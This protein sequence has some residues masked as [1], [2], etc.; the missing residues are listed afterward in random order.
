ML[1][2]DLLQKFGGHASIIISN[3]KTGAKFYYVDP[4]DFK[5]APDNKADA[6]FITHAHYDHFSPED[7]KKILNPNTEIVLVNGCELDVKNKI[8]KTEP[9]KN[10]EISNIKF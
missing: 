3:K 2:I 1:A 5:Q 7:L 10:F 8:T 4:W 6:V 9:N